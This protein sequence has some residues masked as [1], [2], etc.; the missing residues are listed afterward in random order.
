MVGV[1]YG[2]FY[3]RSLRLGKQ[4]RVGQ[5]HMLNTLLAPNVCRFLTE[6]AN[7]GQP[8]LSPFDWGTLA[9]APF[10]PRLNM[11]VGPSATVVIAPA[12]WQLQAETIRLS[13][14]GAEETRWFRG[15][16]LFANSGVSHATSTDRHG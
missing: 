9:A 1:R 3:V 11:K 7:H 10:L 14:E 16:Q 6:I 8:A 12:R 4:V 2:R 15:F 13:G 5:G